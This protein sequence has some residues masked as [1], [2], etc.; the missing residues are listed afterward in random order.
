MANQYFKCER[1]GYEEAKL[2]PDYVKV[3]ET[4][5]PECGGK[6]VRKD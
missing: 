1:C 3:S 5:C 6:M 4:P 2:A